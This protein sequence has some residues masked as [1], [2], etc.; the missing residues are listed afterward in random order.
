MKVAMHYWHNWTLW[1]FEIHIQASG[2]ALFSIRH[3]NRET[4]PVAKNYKTISKRKLNLAKRIYFWKVGCG[5]K[6]LFR[7]AAFS[8]AFREL[9]RIILTVG[10]D[11][12]DDQFKRSHPNPWIGLFFLYD[13]SPKALHYIHASHICASNVHATYD[14]PCST[15]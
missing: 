8:E 12:A 10:A 14:M 9:E 15:G 7:S 4:F 13:T 6:W 3:Q 1:W 2:D 5:I 11:D